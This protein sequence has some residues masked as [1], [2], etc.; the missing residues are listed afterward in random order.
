[1]GGREQPAPSG[2]AQTLPSALFFLHSSLCP[3][4]HPPHVSA[5][6]QPL[7]LPQS[8]LS[9]A[10]RPSLPG[11]LPDP[12]DLYRVSLAAAPC[13]LPF[14]ARAGPSPPGVRSSWHVSSRPLA[15]RGVE[16]RKLLLLTLKGVGPG[17]VQG[18]AAVSGVMGLQPGVITVTTGRDKA[19]ASCLPLPTVVRSR[20]QMPRTYGSER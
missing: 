20:C 3:G 6:S 10:P 14:K 11:S 16:P 13:W 18:G 19:A 5:Q 12:V 9:P 2:R 1:M 17:S 8:P 7:L 4:L 15:G